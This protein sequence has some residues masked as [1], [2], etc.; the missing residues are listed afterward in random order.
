[1][2]DE[3]FLYANNRDRTLLYE[4]VY[5]GTMDY[6][7]F[8]PY[9]LSRYHYRFGDPGPYRNTC[10]VSHCVWDREVIQVLRAL[11][12]KYPKLLEHA[13]DYSEEDLAFEVMQHAVKFIDRMMHD[14][15]TEDLHFVLL[16]RHDPPLLE[17]M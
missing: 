14:Y 10:F 11:V 4:C 6:S 9:D 13:A 3:H 5:L 2:P 7:Y 8:G 15:P 1:M 16:T 12:A 17:P